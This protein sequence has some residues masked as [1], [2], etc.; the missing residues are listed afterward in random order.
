MLFIKNLGRLIAY[1]E[2]SL[3]ALLL[4][5]MIILATSQI[6]MRNLWESGVD[7]SDP[8]LRVLVLWLGLLG[9]MAAT[10]DGNH[11]KIDLLT[12]LLPAAVTRYLPPI[13]NLV[14]AVICGIVCYHASRFV[15]ME[16]E[17]GTTAFA[18]VPAWL[19]EIIIPIGFGLMA[20]R[21]FADAIISLF[22]PQQR[23]AE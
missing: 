3:L 9:A 18:N 14:S 17:D 23:S 21:F 8:L 5:G 7:W 2:E 1:M 12:K 15:M 19:C 22:T 16:Y 20:L 10:R 4:G 13:T 11:I 6:F